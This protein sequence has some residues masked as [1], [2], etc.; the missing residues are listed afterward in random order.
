METAGE[1]RAENRLK[2]RWPVRFFRDGQNQPFQGQIVDISSEGLA[3]LCHADQGNFDTGEPLKTSFGVPYFVCSDFFDTVLFER[4]GYVHRIDKPSSQVYRV[5]LQ[6]SCPLFFKPGQQQIN[7]ADLQMKLEEKNL[8]V[9]KA[10]ESARAY[11]EALMNAQKQLRLYAQAKVKAEEKLKTE[12]EDRS[13][14]E[15]RLRADAE[16]KILLYVEKTARLEEK[17]KTKEKELSRISKIAE[18]SEKKAKSL[19]EQLSR[20]REQ[21]NVEIARIRRE[22]EATISRIRENPKNKRI[23]SA[24]RDLLKKVDE[25]ISDRSKI[26]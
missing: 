15:A 17:L 20:I 18:K 10:E 4:T 5:A 24:K 8:S 2:Y 6:F 16:Q 14:A 23:Q 26:F 21:A 9:I 7:E 1:R 12:I 11:D 3:F 25:I 13:R 22:T 19:D